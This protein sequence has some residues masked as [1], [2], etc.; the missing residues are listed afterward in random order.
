MKAVTYSRYGGPEGLV[1]GE[2]P[3]P[4]TGPDSVLV[5]VRA[6]SVNPVDWKLMAGALGR[7]MYVNFPVTIGRDLAGTVVG[8]GAGAFRF[9][10]GDDVIGYVRLDTVGRGTFAELAAAPV[11]TLA[12][13]PKNLSWAEAGTLPLAGLAAYQTLKTLEVGDDDTVLILN[14]SG[15]VGTF[16]IQ[17]V[18]LPS[19]SPAPWGASGR[20]RLREAPRP[21]APTGCRA[22][23]PR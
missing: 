9:E 8:T 14:G 23:V 22:G 1:Y 3:E 4:K 12:R 10:P 17:I 7:V 21:A 16:A 6:V 2:R 13:K 18:R 5:R 20:H 15:G 19:R 11:R